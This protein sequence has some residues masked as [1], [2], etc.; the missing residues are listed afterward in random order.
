MRFGKIDYLNLAPFDIFIK[1]YPLPSSFKKFLHLHRSYPAKL[2]KDFLFGRIDAGFI[3]SIAGYSSHQKGLATTSGIIAKGAV[4]SV[5]VLPHDAKK[6]YQS[7]TSNAL[8]EVLGLQG[9]VLIGDRALS[10]HYAQNHAKARQAREQR[11]SAK[12]PQKYN[13]SDRSKDIDMGEAWFER[14]GLPFVFGRLCF[15]KH[16]S[17]Y[18]KLSKHFSQKRI[19]IPHYLLESYAA[20][21]QI[22]KKYIQEYLKHIYYHIGTKEML[23]L[24]RFYRELLFR[25]IKKP[26]RFA[27]SLLASTPH[28]SSKTPKDKSNSADCNNPPLQGR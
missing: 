3:S 6:D 20:K 14:H 19:K 4:W 12:K 15:N 18:A 11:S 16:A 22:D 24:K 9:E 8:C 2:N 23:G 1:A 13:K 28:T 26:M 27:S 10:R 17:I 25:R 7:A 5:L 21:S